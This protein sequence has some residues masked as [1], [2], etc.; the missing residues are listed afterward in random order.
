[1]KT[2]IAKDVLLKTFLYVTLVQKFAT[3]SKQ[4]FFP[5]QIRRLGVDLL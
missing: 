3:F 4:F 5:L 2:D 1:M